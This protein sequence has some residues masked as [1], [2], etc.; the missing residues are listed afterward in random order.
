MSKLMMSVVI[1]M[2]AIASVSC[3]ST[4]KFTQMQSELQLSLDEANASLDQCQT[5]LRSTT[6]R[7]STCQS[8]KDKLNT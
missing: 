7:L 8:D 5:T 2:M 4:K 1:A 3:V 6:A